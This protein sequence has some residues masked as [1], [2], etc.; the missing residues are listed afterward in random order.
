[1]NRE[2]R[3]HEIKRFQLTTSLIPLILVK[4]KNLDFS[5]LLSFQ[6]LANKGITAEMTI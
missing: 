6:M 4:T 2:E 5:V 1:M 3:E